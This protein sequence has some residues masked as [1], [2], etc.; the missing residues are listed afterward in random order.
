MII[1]VL[2]IFQ[3]RAHKKT[4]MKPTLGHYVQQIQKGCE[5]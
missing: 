5:N 1:N 3:V 4:F 2:K